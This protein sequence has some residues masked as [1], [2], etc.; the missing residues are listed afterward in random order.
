MML[1]AERK[2]TDRQT[3]EIFLC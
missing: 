1:R 2:Q 3:E